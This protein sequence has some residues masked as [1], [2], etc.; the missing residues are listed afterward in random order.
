MTVLCARRGRGRTLRQEAIDH[1]AGACAGSS[2]SA[3]GGSIDDYSHG[4]IGVR[5]GVQQQEHPRWWRHG[6]GEQAERASGAALARRRRVAQERRPVLR[7][8]QQLHPGNTTP[9][10]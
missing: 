8:I 2:C 4:G 6:G 7:R 1:G 5:G 3:R 10:S 9:Y